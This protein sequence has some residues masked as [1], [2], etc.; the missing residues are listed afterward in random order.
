MRTVV[1]S[2]RARI[3]LRPILP[4]PARPILRTGNVS[5]AP[6]G[7]VLAVGALVGRRPAFTVRQHVLLDHEPARIAL[8][9]LLEH[10]VDVQVALA[11]TAERLA[12]PDLGD[13]RCLAHD[14]LDDRALRVFQVHVVDPRSP[15]V[16]RSPR[17]PAA[18]QQVSRVEAEPDR[19]E[20][21][22]LLDLPRGLDVGAGLVVE[23]RLVAPLAAPGHRFLE[24]AGE[25]P[26]LLGVEAERAVCRPLARARAPEVAAGVGK[27]RLRLE[28][29]LRGDR[30]EHVEQALEVFQ[31]LRHLLRVAEGQLEKASGQAEAAA[32]EIGGQLVA[33]AEVA[34]RSEVDARVA[35]ARDL[36]EDLVGLGY[37]RHDPD[38]ELESTV[39][40]RRVRDLDRV[41]AG[42]FRSC[43]VASCGSDG[44]SIALPVRCAATIASHSAR[45]RSVSRPDVTGCRC[46]VTQAWK[47]ISSSLKLSANEV[48]SSV[49]VERGDCAS[50]SSVASTVGMLRRNGDG[51]E[52]M[53][54]RSGE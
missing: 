28:T 18:E 23:G 12:L 51:N 6:A 19:G 1:E 38:G 53:S 7:Q 33:V 5:E 17:V 50:P 52:R 20:L 39:A 24:V 35:R 8:L 34:E 32:R 16:H 40:D 54:R 48:I 21:E 31:D 37:V 43:A 44:W 10:A 49:R 45:S 13:R 36:V 2:I 42:H 9:Q 11:E 27:G 30:V 46:S 25:T 15:I 29:V 41:L 4:A 26:P 3:W 47:W 14:L 22:H